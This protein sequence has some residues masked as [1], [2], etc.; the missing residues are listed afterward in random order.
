M[1]EARQQLLSE[2]AEFVLAN[3][4]EVTS[5]TLT[6]ALRLCC[7]EEPSLERR[8]ARRRSEG[9]PITSDWLQEITSDYSHGEEEMLNKLVERLET[10]I[11]DFSRT[12]ETARSA[13]NDY[14]EALERHVDDIKSSDGDG[15]K[16][17][18]ELAGYAQ[19]MLE[20]SRKAEAELRHAEEEAEGLRR[21]LERARRDAE[22]DFLTGLRN[23]RSFEVMLEEEYRS[24]RANGEALSVAF[25]DIDRFKVINDTH[26]HAAGDR[27]LCVVA[28]TLAKISDDKC[29]IARHGGEEFVMLFRGSSTVEAAEALDGARR[30]LGARRLMNRRT[31]APFGKVTFSGGV[32]NVFAYDSPRA[33][34]SAADQALYMAK[35]NGRDRI[36]LAED[37]DSVE[38]GV[39]ESG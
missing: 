2:I 20:R 21:N 18:S 12:T 34:L 33:A 32:A 27:V 3:D 37:C 19:A 11:N 25:C 17:L 30:A 39:E 14:N 35:E 4:L 23:R 15:P 1:L 9:M 6:I 16:L 38:T 29:H 5:G 26:G 7:G 8:I 22:F 13:T 10:G 36:M 28:E 24:A 31:G